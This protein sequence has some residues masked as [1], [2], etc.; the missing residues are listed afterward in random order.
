MHVG[1]TSWFFHYFSTVAV[2]GMSLIV[3]FTNVGIAALILA[4]IW[5]ICVL[6]VTF[7]K[8]FKNLDAVDQSVGSM[9][10]A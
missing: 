5:G 7:S 6:G 2:F 10:L 3:S 1:N 8:V 4:A 9:D